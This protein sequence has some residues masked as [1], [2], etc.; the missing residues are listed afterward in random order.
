MNNPRQRKNYYYYFLIAGIV[1]IAAALIASL[2]FTGDEDSLAPNNEQRFE[3]VKEE[4][5]NSENLKL[6]PQRNLN[7][8]TTQQHTILLQASMG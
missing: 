4:F 6:L 5:E 3:I 1:V 8:D 2:T 7:K